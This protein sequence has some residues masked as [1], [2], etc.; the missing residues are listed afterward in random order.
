MHNAQFWIDLFTP[1]IAPLVTW[2]IGHYITK[3]PRALLGPICVALGTLGNGLA[4]IAITGETQWGFAVLLG[5]GG[6]GVRELQNQTR[7]ATGLTVEGFNSK[8]PIL[9]VFLLV[10]FYAPAVL[11]RDVLLLWDPSKPEEKIESY[12]VYRAVASTNSADFL[13]IGT[14]ALPPFTDAGTPSGLL[15]YYVTAKNILGNVSGQSNRVGTSPGAVN[16]KVT[17]IK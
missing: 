9:F 2:L 7:K 15:V 1:F 10:T 8:L 5:L 11:A 4:S 17:E 13:L 3:V 6:I 14:V 16:V 12:Q